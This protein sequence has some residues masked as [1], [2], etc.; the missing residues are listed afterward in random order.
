MVSRLPSI[1][2]GGSVQRPCNCCRA[3]LIKASRLWAE[4]VCLLNK[5]NWKFQKDLHSAPLTSNWCCW[6]SWLLIG[7]SALKVPNPAPVGGVSHPCQSA[8]LACLSSNQPL[9]SSSMVSL[10]LPRGL[11][12]AAVILSLMMVTPPVILVRDPRRKCTTSHVL[13]C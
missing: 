13:S 1:R 8:R 4:A 5:G 12:V 3:T 7:S 2:V 10:W 11:C 6:C 9:L